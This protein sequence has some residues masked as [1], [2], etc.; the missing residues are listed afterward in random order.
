MMKRQ[1]LRVRAPAGEQQEKFLFYRGVSTSSV[2]IS[3]TITSAGKVRVKN[4]NDEATVSSREGTCRR[5]AR[6][7][8]VLSRRLYILRSH[9][10]DDHQRWQGA[11]Q[12]SER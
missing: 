9:L 11:R 12:K 8:S 3:A 5:A 2:P 6:K 1:P 7:I 10:R 4:R